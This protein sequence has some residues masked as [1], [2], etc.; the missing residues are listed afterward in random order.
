MNI[1]AQNIKN[2]TSDNNNDS[3]DFPFR[4]R[5]QPRQPIAKALK[6]KQHMSCVLACDLGFE[7]YEFIGLTLNMN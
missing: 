2:T 3:G 5:D 1:W 7:L 4:V 6:Y